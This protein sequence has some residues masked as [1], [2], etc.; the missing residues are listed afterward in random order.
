MQNERNILKRLVES[1][2]RDDIFLAL[3]VIGEASTNNELR[4]M[5][6]YLK[7]CDRS[8]EK[9][10]QLF[11]LCYVQRRLE[12]FAAAFEN[13]LKAG[14]H[15]LA[16]G[17]YIAGTIVEHSRRLIE[18]TGIEVYDAD[19]YFTKAADAGHIWSRL[20]LLSDYSEKT[21]FTALKS[22][23]FRLLVGPIAVLASTMS[24][25]HGDLVLY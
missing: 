11:A 13:A 22:L 2:E 3:E 20:A 15:G 23:Y 4:E 6:S 16:A 24:R 21:V 8:E 14:N 7:R 19:Y 9:A 10:Y 12:L 18:F 17:Y 1:I 5:E 25:K